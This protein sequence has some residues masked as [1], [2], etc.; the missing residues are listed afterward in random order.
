MNILFENI[1]R[2]HT[3]P[4]GEMRIKTQS[5][6]ERLRPS[7]R[8]QKFNHEP[9]RRNRTHRQKLLY[10][11]QPLPHNGQRPFLHNNNS[12]QNKIKG[13]RNTTCPIALFFIFLNWLI[14]W[15]FSNIIDRFVLTKKCFNVLCV[16]TIK[17]SMGQRL[18]FNN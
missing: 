14:V 5:R 15:G 11:L 4:L 10:T 7:Q 3:T 17:H 6:A 18:C 1:T 16:S 2:L 13:N 12:P 8:N 9:R